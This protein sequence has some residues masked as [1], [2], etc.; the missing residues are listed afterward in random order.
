MAQVTDE[1]FS[2][3]CRVAEA[4]IVANIVSELDGPID[5]KGSAVSGSVIATTVI[6]LPPSVSSAEVNQAVTA[7]TSSLV[8]DIKADSVLGS[9]GT[10]GALQV[11]SETVASGAPPLP[12]TPSIPVISNT[13]S[14]RSRPDHNFT[15]N[16]KDCIMR[17]VF[18]A[19]FESYAT[20]TPVTGFAQDD[21]IVDVITS[22]GSTPD[23]VYQVYQLTAGNQSVVANS[24]YVVSVSAGKKEWGTEHGCGSVTLLVSVP[25]GAAVDASGIATTASQTAT[26]TWFPGVHL[27][28]H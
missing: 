10:I 15:V 23:L 21:I 9:L 26:V 8:N 6:M 11:S 7:L 22:T 5:C 14:L 16:G 28:T 12:V 2:T 24:E 25:A 18:A 3:L 4:R 13:G 20:R 17:V 19:Q 27:C 1:F